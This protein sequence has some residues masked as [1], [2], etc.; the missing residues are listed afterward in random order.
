MEREFSKINGLK[1]KF[2]CNKC[3]FEQ[4]VNI[5]PYINFNENPDYYDLVKNLSI[6]KVECQNCKNNVYIKYDCMFLNEDKK[7]IL[8]V[9]SNKEMIN[10]FR[11]QIRYIVESSLNSDDKY[12]FDEY[13]S[14]LVFNYNELIEKL[15]IF[16]LGL[17]DKIIEILKYGLYK[18]KINTSTKFDT[19]YFD[20]LN[21]MSLEFVLLSSTNNDDFEKFGLN[22]E[23]YNKLTDQLLKIKSYDE[24]FTEINKDWVEQQLNNI[25]KI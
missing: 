4:D 12:N 15:I 20:G 25:N 8:Y 1:E 22:I 13:T 10:S 2:T 11:N 17:N 7:Y 19:V 24:F 3:N 21:G 5:F 23:H 16:E 14:R 6:F 18:N 9:L